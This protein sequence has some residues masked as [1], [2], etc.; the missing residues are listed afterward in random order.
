MVPLPPYYF[1]VIVVNGVVDLVVVMMNGWGVLQV[2]FVSFTKG[3]GGF[4]YVFIIMG[5]V[6]TL[7]P[8]DGITLED[9]GVFVLR[10]DQEVLDGSATFEVSL[11]TI[12]TTDLFDAFTKTLC[13]RYDYVTFT[14][15]FSGGC[16]GT[17][18]TLVVNA[19]NGLTGRP[20]GP[21][22]HLV[23]SP[24]GIFT[25]GESF[26]EVFFSCLS[27][28]GLLHTV[29]ALWERVLITLN[30]AER[31]WWL[32]HCKYWSVWVGFLYTVMDRLPFSSGFTMVSKKGMEPFSLLSTTINFM[33]GSILFMCWRNPCLLTSLW[34]TKVSSANLCQNL[35][36]Q[37]LGLFA[38]ST[39]C[40]GLLL[41]GL[42][43]NPWPHP[44]PVQRTGLGRRN[45]Y[46]SDKIPIGEWCHLYLWLSYPWGWG[47]L[48]TDPLLF[49]RLDLWGLMWKVLTHH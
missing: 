47:P 8:I 18:S 4:P 36:V 2:L 39:P 20:V 14:L 48:P 44:Q 3:P 27:N 21:F 17:V 10:R 28:S 35:G 6:A 23:Q 26:P 32:S 43:G 19:T 38:L 25:F 16:R 42:L 37:C 41:W 1:A 22:L 40:K 24:L 5:E 34:I 45:R 7:I 11:D 9:H 13:V 15:N 33:A 49:F 31:L 46:F 30:L 12:P 29:W